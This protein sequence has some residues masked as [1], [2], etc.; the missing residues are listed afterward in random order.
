MVDLPGA[1]RSSVIFMKENLAPNGSLTVKFVAVYAAYL[2]VGNLIWEIAQLPLYGIWFEAT[3]YEIAYAV[4]HCTA[5]DVLIGLV[6]FALAAWLVTLVHRKRQT[7]VVLFGAAIIFGVTYT[8]FSEWLNVY[9]RQSWSYSELMPL[10]DLRVVSIGLSPIL[11][12]MILPTL[13]FAFHY[14]KVLK[15]FR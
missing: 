10:L 9:V 3:V 12:W 13:F 6:S 1:E 11:Q 2:A 5:G 8:V 14:L 7:D 4:L 15:Q